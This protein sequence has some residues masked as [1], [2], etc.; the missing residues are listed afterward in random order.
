MN[1][2]FEHA[3]EEE[4]PK[5]IK[6][7]IS[8]IKKVGG[9][10]E[11][12]KQLQMRLDL[13]QN[14]AIVGSNSKTTTTTVSP[15]S[16]SLYN[17]VLGTK[18]GNLREQKVVSSSTKSNAEIEPLVQRENK[19]NRFSAVIRNSRP[20]PQ[21][22]GLDQL[23]ELDG[24]IVKERPQYT[25]I[26]RTQAPKPQKSEEDESEQ[27]VTAATNEEL[28]DDEDDVAPK[29]PSTHQPVHQY[30]NIQRARPSSTAAPAEEEQEGEVEDID[31]DD[32]EEVPARVVPTTT[33]RM[34]YVN[35]QR[36]RPTKPQYIQDEV[37]SESPVPETKYDGVDF[38]WK[39]KNFFVINDD[40]TKIC[41]LNFQIPNSES[42]TTDNNS[43]QQ[44]HRWG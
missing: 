40:K 13:N 1:S 30:V 29:N 38:L 43:S 39:N 35:I 24:G 44:H 14:S 7:L 21:N 31:E 42:Q 33:P 12:E 10:D 17:K 34:Q 9:L 5:V 15:I 25:T 41:F 18:R 2:K 8:L 19:G 23:P 16:Q 11:L 28:S 26:T 3:L 27:T 22:D 36:I 20:R 6:E 4:D 37:E 32:E